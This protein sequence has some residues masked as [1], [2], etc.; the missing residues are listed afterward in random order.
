MMAFE[1]VAIQLVDLPAVSEQH[2]EPWVF[3]LVRAAD[4]L[5]IVLDITSAVDGLAEVQRLLQSHALPVA[6]VEPVGRSDHE[7]TRPKPALLV[8]T[9][10]DRPDA[11]E[12]LE[13][14]DSLLDRR[15]T[16]V[17]VSAPSGAGLDDLR[18][19]TFR[20]FNA[21]R[22][23]TKQPGKA[24][25]RSSPYVLPRGSTVG[26]LAAHIHKDLLGQM[27]FARVWGP[28]AFDGQTVHR[29]HVLADG[30]VVEIHA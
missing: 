6:P 23:Y 27:R 12:W 28:S 2:V 19:R 14:T 13:L 15:W 3:D 17:V 21:I 8:L 20:A 11:A 30:D 16:K 10:A 22:I 4:L 26:D 5:W 18:E 24:P 1:D 7:G 9:G 29:D 25:D